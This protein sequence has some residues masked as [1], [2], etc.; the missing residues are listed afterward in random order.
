MANN[1]GGPAF[2]SQQEQTPDGYW[3]QTWSP[4]MS[5]RDWFAG[6]AAQGIL[7]QQGITEINSYDVAITA[8]L[9]ADAMIK[10]RDKP[11]GK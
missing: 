5:L 1:D 9:T 6:M 7:S 2:P 10:E 11:D 3:N 4:G 8:Y